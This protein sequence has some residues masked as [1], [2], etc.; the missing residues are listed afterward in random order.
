[1][2]AGVGVVLDGGD[3]AD[4]AAVPDGEEILRFGMLEEGILARREEGPDVHPQLRHPERVA[5]VQ[6][7]RKADEPLQTAPVRDGHDLRS[8]QM[9][10]S[11][12]PSR[13]KTS[14]AWSIC[15]AVWVAIKLVRSRQCDGGT[16]GGTTGLVN[17]PASN[18]LRQNRNV[19]SSGPIRTGTIGVAVGPMSKPSERSPCWSRRVFCHRQSRRSRPRCRMW[20]AARTPPGVAGGN[21]ARENRGRGF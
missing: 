12:F 6:V 17:T 3:A 8:A 11:S 14:S 21:A 7:V 16:A 10:P 5:A 1:M 13:P 2:L 15:C 20:S 9:T 19:F 18:S 4:R